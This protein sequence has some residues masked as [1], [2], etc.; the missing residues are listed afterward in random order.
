MC[1]V[2]GEGY[3]YC[4]LL[5]WNAWFCYF[6]LLRAF[7]FAATILSARSLRYKN[8]VF[9]PSRCVNLFGVCNVRFVFFLRKIARVYLALARGKDGGWNINILCCYKEYH[10]H[11]CPS[12]FSFFLANDKIF[13][14]F[15]LL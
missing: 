4:V 14:H 5:F 1:F 7:S 2:Y 3:F 9:I 13:F 10:F 15:M 6:V 11:R 8:L 12:I